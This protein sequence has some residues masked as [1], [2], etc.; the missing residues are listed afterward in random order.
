MNKIYVNELK[1][2]KKDLEKEN[3]DI[4]EYLLYCIDKKLE[5]LPGEKTV[6]VVDY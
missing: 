1:K 6:D 2:L 5:M 4:K 3:I